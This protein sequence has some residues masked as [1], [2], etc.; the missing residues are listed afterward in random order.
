MPRVRDLTAP[1]KPRTKPRAP[2]KLPEAK[3]IQV[4]APAPPEEILT[5]REAAA[6]VKMS[7]AWFERKRWE[8]HGG[9]PYRRRGRTVRYLKSELLAWWAEERLG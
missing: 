1:L 8:G 6:L 5:T 3:V 7:E 9:P 2:K 4:A